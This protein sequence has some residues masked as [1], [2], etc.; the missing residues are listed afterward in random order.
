MFSYR[1][2]ASILAGDLSP[3][4]LRFAPERPSVAACHFASMPNCRR[5]PLDSF[6]LL[7]LFEALC[8]CRIPSGSWPQQRVLDCTTRR[9]LRRAPVAVVSCAPTT[10]SSDGHLT[11]SLA[12]VAIK[13]QF[14]RQLFGVH[15]SPLAMNC[16]LYSAL[17]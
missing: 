7:V 9:P 3:L 10:S 11:K 12:G 1:A 13:V 16:V 2:A 8:H 15:L 4:F 6:D 17:R 5:S 14:N